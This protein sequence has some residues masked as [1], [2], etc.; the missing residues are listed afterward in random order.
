MLP[1]NIWMFVDLVREKPEKFVLE[2]GTGGGQ[3]SVLIASHLPEKTIFTIDWFQGLPKSSK[4]IPE[5]INWE[6]GNYVYEE[7]LTKSVI[8]PY[9]NIVL[10]KSRI[11]DLK[12]PDFYGIEDSI[13]AVNIDV[14]IYDSTVSS[15]EYVNKC[16]WDFIYIRFD[17]WH[18]EDPKFYDHEQLAF[19]EFIDQYKYNYEILDSFYTGL[20][21]VKR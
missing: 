19:Q 21:W 20:V 14:D 1:N 3:S 11:E 12:S 16:K 6:E 15:L 10:I 9:P 2:F 17:D 8:D 4:A 13:A 5:G 18:S 7:I